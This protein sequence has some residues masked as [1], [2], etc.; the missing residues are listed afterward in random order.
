MRTENIGDSGYV[1]TVFIDA[2]ADKEANISFYKMFL[3]PHNIKI[4]N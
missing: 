3:S 1:L 4:K 2:F